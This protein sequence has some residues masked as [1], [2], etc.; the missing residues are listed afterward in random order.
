MQSFSLSGAVEFDLSLYLCPGASITVNGTLY[1]QSNPQGSELIPG[2]S[3]FGCDSIVHVDLAFDQAAVHTIEQMMCSG[4]SITVNGTVYNEQN[5][6]G[7]EV[8]PHASSN[9]CDSTV[10]INLEF[11]E[12]SEIYIANSLCPEDGMIV[13]GTV[14]NIS[15][16]TGTEIIT[17]GNATGCDSIIYVDPDFYPI[18]EAWLQESWCPGEQ[19]LINGTLYHEGYSSGT[20]V[21]SNATANGCDSVLH[22]QLDFPPPAELYIERSL[23]MNDQ[24]LSMVPF[25]TAVTLPEQK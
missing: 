8:L 22:I 18:T 12:T 5:P 6:S 13:N 20:E 14:Y 24:V 3:V 21:F 16:P 15:Q 11:G 23:C 4:E 1:D 10:Y 17:G 2:G 9:G 7:T 19:Q 25:I